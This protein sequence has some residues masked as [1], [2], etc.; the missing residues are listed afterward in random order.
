MGKVYVATAVAHHSGRRV[1]AVTLV[2]GLAAAVVA[3][4]NGGQLGSV[5]AAD[6]LQHPAYPTYVVVG[7]ADEGEEALDRLLAQHPHARQPCGNSFHALIAARPF[8]IQR[9]EWRVQLEIVAKLVPNLTAVF[10]SLARQAAILCIRRSLSQREQPPA[11]DPDPDRLISRLTVP[12]KA[13]PILERR[14]QAQLA[15][16]DCKRVPSHFLQR[17]FVVSTVGP[18]CRT[19]GHARAHKSPSHS[20]NTSRP[21]PKVC[22]ACVRACV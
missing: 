9:C 20:H 18:L 21:K 14:L 2:A 15:R 8:L 19:A 1:G 12:A 7:R 16:R 22:V 5:R 17:V 13:L 4:P 6:G 11:Q 3:A 10:V